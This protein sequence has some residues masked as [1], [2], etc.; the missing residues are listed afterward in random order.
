MSTAPDRS[1][2]RLAALALAAAA[3]LATLAGLDGLAKQDSGA[4]LAKAAVSAPR[5]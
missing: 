5:G 3:T 4:Q 1:V 2:S